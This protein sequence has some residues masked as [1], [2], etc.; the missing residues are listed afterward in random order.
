[1]SGKLGLGW[2]RTAGSHEHLINIVSRFKPDFVLLIVEDTGT[3]FVLGLTSTL[4]SMR[5]SVYFYPIIVR[6]RKEEVYDFWDNVFRA[7]DGVG[8]VRVLPQG[9]IRMLS[10]TKDFNDSD[11]VEVF[12]LETR[13]LRFWDNEFRVNKSAI[14]KT[15]SLVKKAREAGKDLAVYPIPPIGFRGVREQYNNLLGGL[16]KIRA[17]WVIE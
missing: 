5:T 14:R 17:W 16:A 11:G 1:M 10:K 2:G 12:A 13:A 3:D 8:E 7:F 9:A 15:R 4:L 6:R